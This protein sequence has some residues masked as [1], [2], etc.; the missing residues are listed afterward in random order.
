MN[1]GTNT[2]KIGERQ[3]TKN[4]RERTVAETEHY[5]HLHTHNHNMKRKK[6]RKKRT[7]YCTVRIITYFALKVYISKKIFFSRFRIGLAWSKSVF[8]IAPVVAKY[9]RFV[10]QKEDV[11]SRKKYSTDYVFQRF[12]LAFDILIITNI[13]NHSFLTNAFQYIRKCACININK[14]QS[15]LANISMNMSIN[16]PTY[17]R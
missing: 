5:M 1:V 6:E 2:G 8:V 13:I 17:L 12:L 4:N 14:V 3:R 15:L 10:K 9:H 7:K 16:N 11:R